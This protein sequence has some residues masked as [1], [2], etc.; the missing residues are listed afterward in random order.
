[1]QSQ[2]TE[3]TLKSS[4][5]IYI[6]RGT[7]KHDEVGESVGRTPERE[8]RIRFG[9]REEAFSPRDLRQ[10]GVVSAQMGGVR[11]RF[12]IDP[13]DISSRWRD[14][15]V[16][17]VCELVAGAPGALNVSLIRSE[18]ESC[19]LLGSGDVA[20]WDDLF[21]KLSADG[22]VVVTTIGDSDYLTARKPESSPKEDRVHSADQDH[23]SVELYL[24]G[25]TEALGRAAEALEGLE[26]TEAAEVVMRAF[27]ACVSS[28][29][30]LTPAAISRLNKLS[31][32]SGNLATGLFA[33]MAR[34][35]AETIVTST[36]T[37]RRDLAE[38]FLTLLGSWLDDDATKE[39]IEASAEDLLA[40][41]RLPA[42]SKAWKPKGPRVTTISA[43]AAT[44]R[45]DD[46]L[47]DP[48]IWKG[49]QWETLM[50]LLEFERTGE[51]LVSP[52]LRESVLRPAIAN[53]MA[54]KE[55]AVRRLADLTTAPTPLQEL[56]TVDQVSKLLLVMSRQSRQVDDAL[57]KR[58][59]QAV[60]D[61][62]PRIRA[63]VTAEVEADSA[64][65]RADLEAQTE[66][67]ASLDGE[68]H[69]VRE[70]LEATTRRLRAEADRPR[71]EAALAGERMAA[72]ARYAQIAVFRALADLLAALA[73][74]AEQDASI[75]TLRSTHEQRAVAMGL[76]AFATPGEVV[77]FDPT[78]HESVDE[79]T[80]TVRVRHCGYQLTGDPPTVVTKAVVEAP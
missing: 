11:H 34:L 43:L 31:S 57:R 69:D 48:Q 64:A 63:D 6:R 70:Q 62:E 46:Q 8:L 74:P 47:T 73:P 58:E 12:G 29:E 80:A 55:P 26:S 44:G 13:D 2:G 14:D 36:R 50:R 56:V 79:P 21:T 10:Q 49:V 19:G 75:R 20:T 22:R 68:L 16:S 60:A 52:T 67:V 4:P 76:V 5:T 25:M 38:A 35:A 77:D 59:L 40:L 28:D 9:S 42:P 24:A 30:S 54:T 18:A 78:R 51:L 15:P 23:D 66:H 33:A 3:P 7:D 45:F 1:M 65:T 72:Q 41:L 37:D 61:S 17:V 32:A 53:R 39:H 71:R 27:R